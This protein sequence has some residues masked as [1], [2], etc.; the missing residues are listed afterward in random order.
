MREAPVKEG[1]RS[2]N[3]PKVDLNL[4]SCSTVLTLSQGRGT[5]SRVRLRLRNPIVQTQR[6]R[7]RER[8][9]Q[10]DEINGRT[11]GGQE[12]AHPAAAAPPAIAA[13]PIS[14]WAKMY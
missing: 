7:D 12:D 4:D 2:D 6:E 3:Y 5:P 10:M 1:S 14:H 11:H 13:G 9:R 8:E